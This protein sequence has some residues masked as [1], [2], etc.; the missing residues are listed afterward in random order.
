MFGSESQAPVHDK[1]GGI[2]KADAVSCY[3]RGLSLQ[4]LGRQE[5]AIVCYEQA[6]DINPC[7]A[8]AHNRLGVANY[9]SGRLAEAIGHYEQAL[10]ANPRL[11]EAHSNLGVVLKALGDPIKAILHHQTSLRL[12]P[13]ELA[14]RLS[15]AKCL[16]D[17]PLA[18]AGEA[19]R[20][21]L[22]ET[23]SF[24]GLNHQNLAFAGATLL[25][26]SPDFNRLATFLRSGS[27]EGSLETLLE[28]GLREVCSDPLFLALLKKTII[29]DPLIE[30]I[31]T[32]TRRALLE[33]AVRAGL[34]DQEEPGL[35]SFI[36]ALAQQCFFNEYVYSVSPA[37][38]VQVEELRSLVTSGRDLGGNER[39]LIGILACYIPLCDLEH[40]RWLT[41][42]IDESG[43][44]G[45]S[46]M[47]RTQVLEPVEE[48]ELRGKIRSLGRTEDEISQAVRAQYEENPYPRWLSTD[49]VEGKTVRRMLREL[50]PHLPPERIPDLQAPDILIAGCGTGRRAINRALGFHSSRVLAVDLSLSSLSY[51]TR[52]ARELGISNL[53]LVH[54]DLLNVHL[55]GRQ[56]DVIESVGVLHH[57][58]DPIQGWRALASCLR[59]GG[60][61]K[62]GLYSETARK[63]IVAAQSFVAERGFTAVPEEIRRCRQEI[64]A[65]PEDAPARGVARIMDFYTL[66]ETRDL[67]FHVQEKRFSLPQIAEAIDGLGLKLIGF[68][69]EDQAQLK[70]Y[71]ARFPED[72]EATSIDNWHQLELENPDVFLALY[73]FWVQ[74][75]AE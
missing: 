23:F 48:K 22:I 57:M 55:L 67:I 69:L 45:Y 17:V 49:R 74:S 14:Y 58:A 13:G 41:G 53:E 65:M 38:A 61:M 11:A 10:A 40:D 29:R 59:P 5:D 39:R 21:D 20:R 72:P 2:Q 75:S 63:D 19:L 42:L 52:K 7:F 47:I 16:S 43:H 66:S 28:A 12:C 4:E 54:A 44:S 33:A 26:N 27:E 36:H 25:R 15:F 24:D 30:T 18:K 60:L 3:C 62:I 73:L 46:E 56:F 32:R 35:T 34:R 1:T 51:A 50:F 71:L 68:E 37:E 64:L 6:L 8:E 9:E 31:L 70:K